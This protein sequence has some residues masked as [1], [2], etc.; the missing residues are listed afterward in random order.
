MQYFHKKS[1]MGF[2]DDHEIRHELKAE[3]V[4][5]PELSCAGYNAGDI[6]S[7]E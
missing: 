4:V 2:L 6:F 7:H 3:E 5:G 1:K